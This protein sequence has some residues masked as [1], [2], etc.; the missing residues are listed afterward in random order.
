MQDRLVNTPQRPHGD[1]LDVPNIL[2][3]QQRCQHGGD[4]ERPD[5]CARQRVRVSPR[6]RA[7]DLSFDALHGEQRKK[8]RQRDRGGEEN[9]FVHLKA[10]REDHLKSLGPFLRR[11]WGR[12]VPQE[13]TL[14]AL[15]RL[16]ITE[17][18]L[19]EDDA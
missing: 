17:N 1:R 19:D 2:G 8:R 16:E 18:V 4:G 12:V 11:R 13:L 10:A 15:A 3:E 6:H 7:K 5:Q 14:L 9:G